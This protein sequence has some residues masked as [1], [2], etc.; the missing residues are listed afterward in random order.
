MGY[1]SE[2]NIIQNPYYK[3][4]QLVELYNYLIEDG[5]SVS[6]KWDTGAIQYS[7]EAGDWLELPKS[8]I[9]RFEEILIN[10]SKSLAW[11]CFMLHNQKLDKA[12]WLTQLDNNFSIELQITS[13]D[14]EEIV[15]FNEFHNEIINGIKKLKHVNYVEWRTDYENKLIRMQTDLNHEGVLILCSS[16]GL[17]EFYK[18]NKF[19]YE[20]PQGLYSL[21]N[22]KIAIAIDS[23]DF[24]Y[25]TIIETVKITDWKSGY[26]NS[27]DFSDNDE[28]L[29]LHH[30]DFTMICDKHGGDYIS[31]GWKNI[32]SIPIEKKKDQVILIAKPK[33]KED[34]RL[35]FQF[36]NI[37]RRLNK[38][39]W[40]EYEGIPTHNNVHDDH[41]G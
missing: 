9:S 8:D 15:R 29:V 3:E 35:I 16:N 32:I 26:Y 30:G 12:I 40:I 28:L 38:N 21:F 24:E 14:E 5:W 17:K 19:D 2:I 36:T 1:R 20:Y 23:K 27:I 13:N 7:I 39:Y 4:N 11:T 10:Q 31:Y 37:E 18:K 22:Q 6:T 25:T 41:V 34:K 33:D